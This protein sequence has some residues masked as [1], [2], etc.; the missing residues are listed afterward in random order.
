MG[1]M[2]NSS[3]VKVDESQKVKTDKSAYLK[4]LADLPKLDPR[5]EKIFSIN[6]KKKKENQ[7][8]LGIFL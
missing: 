7:D 3:S 2:F 1:G 6:T 4:T 5:A 8:N